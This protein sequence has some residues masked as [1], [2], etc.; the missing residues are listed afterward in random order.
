VAVVYRSK[1]ALDLADRQLVNLIDDAD[2]GPGFRSRAISARRPTPQLT[3]VGTARL[4]W[5]PVTRQHFRNQ[6][7]T[8]EPTA[9]SECASSRQLAQAG[10][11]TRC[12]DAGSG[13]ELQDPVVAV[14]RASPTVAV[15]GR[16]P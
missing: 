7:G 14:P 5:R 6:I 1:R 10:P 15:A 4:R 13:P 2:P 11:N 16:E 9:R 8:L 3:H 12:S